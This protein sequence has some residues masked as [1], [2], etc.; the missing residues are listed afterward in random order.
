VNLPGQG[1]DDRCLFSISDRSAVDHM[2]MPENR[3]DSRN[4]QRVMTVFKAAR[5][6]G[7][8]GDDLGLIRNISTEGVM[9]ETQLMLQVDEAVFIEV[10]SGNPMYGHV[11]WSKDGMA[12]IHLDRPIEI[13]EA[14]RTSSAADVVDRIRPP[15][16]ERVLDATLECNGR[17]WPARM[18]NI[19]LSGAQI[20]PEKALLLPRN[21][22]AILQVEGLGALGG[23]LRWQRAGSIGMR[24]EHALALRQF[25]QWLHE[26]GDCRPTEAGSDNP[27][28]PPQL[29][30]V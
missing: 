13:A 17:S 24:F 22:H 11:R 4:G 6:G 15:R 27:S 3:T 16:F 8:R 26:F 29:R 28:A 30:A 25:Q 1:N 5:I 21:A 20:V 23:V 14:L 10:Q 18:R 2:T 9:V 19:S 12:G 7:A